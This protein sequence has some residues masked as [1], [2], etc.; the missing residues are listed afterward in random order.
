[1][2]QMNDFG[3]EPAALREAM[4]AAIR[5]VIDSGWYVLGDEV[6]S[7]EEQWAAVCGTACAVG[8][9]NGMDAIEIA[10]RTL[11]IGPGD[12]V[13][14]TSMTAYATVLAILRA[15]AIPV[16]ADIE[17]DTALLSLESAQ[18]CISSRTKAVILV[19]L[20]GQVRKMAAWIEFCHENNAWL[21][22][23]CAQSHLASWQGKV[24]GNF[25]EVG[26]YSFYPTKNLGTLG[27]GGMLVT[28]N[29]CLAADAMRMRN[30]GQSDRYHHPEFGMNS[31]L[32][33]L[34]AAILRE[35]I[36]WLK[37][38]T[39]RRRSIAHAY[40]VG[41]TNSLVKK[42]IPPEEDAAHVYHLYVVTCKW[43]DALQFHLN[44]N[45]VQALIHYPIPV[46][47]QKQCLQ[48]MRDPCGLPVSEYHAAMCLTLPVHPQMSDADVTQVISAVNSFRGD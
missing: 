43:R 20:Y 39:E 1:M 14:T 8:V 16:L 29:L 26:A 47:H 33:E 22:E 38:F 17:P 28:N 34:H 11:N 32:D 6:R 2:I 44:K 36:K 30:Y 21:I 12:E 24:A 40:E 15:G 41:I 31:R 7:F 5:R 4:L 10:L 46:H 18:R 35:R 42:M 45:Q 25:G 23:D 3:A 27:D 9:G 13:I 19:H 48:I 37:I